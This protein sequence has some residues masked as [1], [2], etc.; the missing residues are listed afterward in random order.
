MR[1]PQI[2]GDGIAMAQVVK[3]SGPR[4]SSLEYCMQW[5]TPQS[6]VSTSPKPSG[7]DRTIMQES[8]L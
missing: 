3:W 4:E 2:F 5:F 6:R 1:Q 8:K 7:P